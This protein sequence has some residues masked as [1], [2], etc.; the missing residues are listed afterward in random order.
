MKILTQVIFKSLP[1]PAFITISTTPILRPLLLVKVHI[2]DLSLIQHLLCLLLNQTSLVTDASYAP[3]DQFAARTPLK[4]T[5][6]LTLSS[7]VRSSDMLNNSVS[8]LSN[9]SKSDQEESI[10]LFNNLREELTTV[11]TSLSTSI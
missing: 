10:K 2:P 9:V 5:P 4:P 1:P 7:P 3:Y 11:M 6:T 8:D